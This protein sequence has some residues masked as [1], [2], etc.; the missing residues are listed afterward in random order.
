MAIPVQDAVE[1]LAVGA[2]H[3]RLL[4]LVG[5]II[6]LDGFDIQLAAFAG[7]AILADW[8]LTTA[9]LAPAMAAALVGMAIGTGVGGA[10]GDRIGRRPAL[11]A[12]VIWF[13]MTAMLTALVGNVTQ[14]AILRFITGLGL[15][16]AVPNATALVAEWMPARL[17]AYAVTAVIVAVPCG[18]MIGAALASWLI[19][20]F[21][22]HAAFALGGGLPLVLALIMARVLPESPIFLARKREAD[23][24]IA[25]LLAKA[26]GVFTGHFTPPP[27]IAGGG[28]VYAAPLTRSAIGLGIAFFASMLALY[29][30]LSWIPVLLSGAG[31]PLAQAIRGAM[32]FNLCGVLASFAATWAVPRLG[33]RPTLLLVCAVAL[34]A[35]GAWAWSLHAPGVSPGAI[36][37][38]VGA[39][40]AGIVAVQVMLY[41][42]AAAVFPVECRAAGIGYSASIGRI[43]A[44]AS[45]LGAGL[46]LGLPGGPA[47][48]FTMIGVA[49]IGIA[50]GVALVD[51]HPPTRAVTRMQ[52]G[53]AKSDA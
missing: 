18:G 12:S 8:G 38:G 48:F 11:I 14:F 15:G 32:I 53:M 28:G 29:A 3:R 23:A 4:A 41:G 35:T 2:F 1:G 9:A 50:L 22:G 33:S 49:I 30:C 7:P 36:L 47:L 46:V 45:A 39:A 16:A 52:A 27:A 37:I 42:L 24:R 13:G 6:L 34:A 25:T 21:G 19:P 10:I 26:G 44:I 40:G 17:R 5:G 31:F 43:G 20:A 51:R